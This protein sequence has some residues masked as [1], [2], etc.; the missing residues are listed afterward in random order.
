[1]DGSL[2]MSM[3]NNFHRVNC[4]GF[5]KQ[6]G[7]ASLLISLV[8]LALITVVTL[9]ASKSILTEQKIA[10]NDVRAKQ[11]FEAAEAG[12]SA[13]ITYL[14]ENP[15]RDGVGGIDPVF[16]TDADGVGDVNTTTIGTNNLVEVKILSPLNQFNSIRVRSK[17]YSDDRMAT[18]SVFSVLSVVDPIPNVPS[19]PLTTRGTVTI[20]GSATISNSEGYSTVWSGG[21]VDLGSNNATATEIADMADA[22][23]PGCMN[24]SVN[25]PG[26]CG[27]VASSNKVMTGPDVVKYDANLGNLSQPRFFENFFGMQPGTYQSSMVSL[28]TTAALVNTSAQ[29]SVNEII[30]VEGNTTFSGITV[31]CT[32]VVNGNNV[33]PSTDTK[34]SIIII[35]G[36][37]TFNG[38]NKFYGVVF[39]MGAV[40]MTGS[41]T[42]TGALV[43]GGAINS[44]AGGS[45][46]ILYS[47]NLLDRVRLNGP[48]GIATGSWADFCVTPLDCLG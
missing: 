34:P 36:D 24:I 21:D 30:W 22:N 43:A 35:N 7:A 2:T 3:D 17:G 13:A 20:T 37:A 31:G 46:D 28:D 18:R 10:N 48:L 45:V 6:N 27:V 8:V 5:A 47:S 42:V 11:A 40:N 19:N 41:T 44:N 15:D 25:N 29:L 16:D 4:P 26:A 14:S 23:Y 32:T 39:V 12:L 9:F 38:N 1:M 33:C